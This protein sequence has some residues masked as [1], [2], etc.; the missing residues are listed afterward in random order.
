MGDQAR[1]KAATYYLYMGEYVEDAEK[2]LNKFHVYIAPICNVISLPKP[3][4]E[5]KMIKTCLSA[6]SSAKRVAEKSVKQMITGVLGE[7][8]VGKF[9]KQKKYRCKHMLLDGNGGHK[10]TT[11]PCV[12]LT[13]GTNLVECFFEVHAVYKWSM[14]Y[15]CFMPALWRTWFDSFKRV[16]YAMKSKGYAVTSDKL[17]ARKCYLDNATKC[18]ADI[19]QV[20]AF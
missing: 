6:S 18:K 19:Q 8:N 17:Q 16:Y 7:P 3:Y 12:D 15:D 5:N 10:L 11:Q 13:Q 4:L 1:A 20:P 14:Q 9:A 2:D